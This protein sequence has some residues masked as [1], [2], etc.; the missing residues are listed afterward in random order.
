MTARRP[1]SPLASLRRVRVGSTSGPK[2]E[3]VRNALSAFAPEARV[4][5]LEVESGVPEQPLGFE[6]IV[7]GARFRAERAARDAE[8]GVGIE[9]GLVA[10]PV[11]T[12]DLQHLNV[13]CCAVTDGTRVGL[14]FS[15]AFAYPP[16]CTLPAVNEREPIGPVFD[17]FWELK[18][19]ELKRPE[20]QR[21]ELAPRP[22]GG[23]VGNVG[24]LSLG[25]LTRGEYARHAVLCALLPFLHPDLY[26][27]PA[28]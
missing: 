8:L 6:E 19:P 18:R 2:I 10:L 5:G 21:G 1:A 9:D 4:E 20:L 7:R 14:G 3:A 15:S 27:G 28:T 13:G 25:V 17:R 23:T 11:D 16:S 24:K 22:S 12:G 26:A